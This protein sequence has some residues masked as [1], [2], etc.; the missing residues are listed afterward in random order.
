MVIVALAFPAGLREFFNRPSLYRH[1]LFAHI[2]SVTLFFAN[3]VVGILWEL[4]SLASGKKEVILHTYNT[5]TWLDARFSVPMI[6]ISVSAG[7][8]LTIMLGDIW[9]IGWLSVAF[10]L[11]VLS[12]LV[13]VSGDIPTQYRIKRLIRNV[14][15]T[16]HDLPPELTRLMKMRVWISIGDV[17]PL[18]VVF[19]LM[20]YKPEIVPVA[21]WFQSR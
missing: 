6:I 10:L 18:I 4:R 16:E 9:R 20:V 7:I 5:V 1:V 13:Y 15:P 19:I 12:G 3:A 8:A 11:F 21:E 2:V 14:D 17:L